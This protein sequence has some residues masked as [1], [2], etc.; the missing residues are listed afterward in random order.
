M[1]VTH[2]RLVYKLMAIV[3]GAFIFSWALVPLYDV[4]CQVTGLNGKTRNVAESYTGVSDNKR[5]VTVQFVTTV[6]RGL[7][8]NFYPKTASVRVHPGTSRN[9][10]F[11]GK[12]YRAYCHTR[13]GYTQCHPRCCCVLLQKNRML[14]F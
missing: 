11:C 3:L 12:E 4:L 1:Q 2:K 13:S 9:G 5:W 10:D 8:W 6:M 7:G 14:L